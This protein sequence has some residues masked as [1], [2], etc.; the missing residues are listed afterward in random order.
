MPSA[1]SDGDDYLNTNEILRTYFF[2]LFELLLPLARADLSSFV[3]WYVFEEKNKCVFT[4]KTIKTNATLELAS[5][6]LPAFSAAKWKQLKL[7]FLIKQLKPEKT[8]RMQTSDF[9]I[10]IWAAANENSLKLWILLI[11]H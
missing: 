1:A 3:K 9:I 5:E 11:Y 4:Q 6:A 7:L 10:F 8:H 2:A